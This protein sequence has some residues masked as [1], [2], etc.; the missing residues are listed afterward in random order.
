MWWIMNDRACAARCSSHAGL[1]GA[2]G[3]HGTVARRILSGV[4]ESWVLVWQAG[5]RGL[6]GPHTSAVF[7]DR[8][9]NNKVKFQHFWK[10]P[11][12][13]S[14]AVSTQHS[15]SP[16]RGHAIIHFSAKV[17][18][19]TV[20]STHLHSNQPYSQNT[21]IWSFLKQ[22]WLSSGHWVYSKQRDQKILESRAWH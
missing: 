3:F 6:G 7:K 19:V 14:E 15:L 16:N 2:V 21:K 1:R 11:R 9:E 22:Y 20:I 5:R 10:P 12:G 17:I 13:S 8:L 4:G 18:Q